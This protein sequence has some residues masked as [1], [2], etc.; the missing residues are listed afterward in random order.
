MAVDNLRPTILH[1]F[2][3]SVPGGV[4]R[5]VVD[6]AEASVAAGQT[7]VLAGQKGDWHSLVERASL[8]WLEIPIRGG[9]LDLWRSSRLVA[10][11]VRKRGV[12]VIHAHHRR[13]TLV[14]RVVQWQLRN[15]QR[16]PILYTLHAIN[17][18][19]G[20]PWRWLS[21]FGDHCHAPSVVARRWLVDIAKIDENAITVIPHGVHPERFPRTDINRRHAAREFLH[22]PQHAPVAAFVGRLDDPKNEAWV[23]GL[24]AE[25][26]RRGMDVRFLI[27]G[28][29]PNRTILE[30]QI[31]GL[32]LEDRVKMLGE[33]DPVKAY[34]AAD[35]LVSPS[36]HEGFSY[37]CAEA[38]CCGVPVLRTR[39]GGTEEMV[40]EN[41]TGRSCPIDREAFIAAGVEM[42]QQPERLAEMGMLA[43]RHVRKELTF[44]R[45]ASET[46]G[47]YRRLHAPPTPANAARGAS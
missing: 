9:V 37:V 18:P 8:P 30:Q 45:Q 36:S 22:L 33:C 35:L 47:L 42:L 27:A 5:Y 23:V 3:G 25:C 40:V 39:T 44:D 46:L 28:D 19:M 34:H 32:G 38:M 43:A 14:A 6:I 13:A 12:G 29:G 31:K 20:I 41:V 4:L 16:L 11:L 7:V 21:S 1:L 10:D 17:M 15:E 24:A 26:R 2:I